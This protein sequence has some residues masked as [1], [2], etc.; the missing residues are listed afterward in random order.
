VSRN[1]LQYCS[2]AISVLNSQFEASRIIKHNAA[3]GSIRE[4]IIKDFLRSHLPELVS[5][6][7]GLIIDVDD[8]YSKQ[9]DIVLVLKSIP[10]LQFASSQD[11]IFQDGVV[12]T[13]EVKSRLDAATMRSIGE[14]IKSV[15]D[16]KSAIATTASMGVVHNWPQNKILTA[17]VCYDGILFDSIHS[18]LEELGDDSRPDLILDLS[19]GLLIRNHGLLTPKNG[20]QSY[21]LM[22]GANQ[23]FAF[24]LTVLTEI[25][26]TLSS[27]GIQWRRYL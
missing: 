15:R 6:I 1:F 10:R 27:R 17:I 13:I 26:G 2:G 7:S 9:Q 11:L 22:N 19:K 8:N 18:T 16:L 25:T 3:A 12:A 24:F 21:I 20:A 14:N 23:G 5:V 4:Q